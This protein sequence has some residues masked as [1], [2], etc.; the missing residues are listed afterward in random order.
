[1]PAGSG[2]ILPVLST[3][4]TRQTADLHC[5]RT[6]TSPHVAWGWPWGTAEAGNRASGDKGSGLGAA[7]PPSHPG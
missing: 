4:A 7:A 2:R 5:D 3:P 6:P 1:M